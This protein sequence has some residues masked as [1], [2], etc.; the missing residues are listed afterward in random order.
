MSPSHISRLLSCVST[1][2]LLLCLGFAV[3]TLASLRNSVDETLRLKERASEVLSDFDARLAGLILPESD[4]T[5]NIPVSVDPAD[6]PT[7]TDLLSAPLVIRDIGGR[8]GVY[9][10]DGYLIREIAVDPSL[11]P[12]ADRQALLAGVEVRSYR[13]L[14]ERIQDYE[15]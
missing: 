12:A 1:L 11:L 13:E 8:I 14:I 6:D 15:G 4:E 7:E 2:L 10:P 3:A 5:E 9:S